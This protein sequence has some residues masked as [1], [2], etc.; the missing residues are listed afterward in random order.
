MI[1]SPVGE[2]VGQGFTQ[3]AGSAHA[4]VVALQ[5]AASQ[6]HDVRGA[7]AYV[8]M[9][10]CSHHGKTG[11][12]SEALI[13][14]GI[15]KVV[16]SVMDPNPLVSGRGFDRLRAAG[17]DVEIGPGAH[18]SRELNIGFFSRMLRKTPWVR[19]KIA[20]SLDGTTGLDN[21]LS[22]WITS[23]P[24][25]ADG[26]TWRARSCAILTGSGTILSDDP[27]L[28]VRGFTMPRQPAVVVVDSALN[29][30]LDAKIF[31][32][33]RDCYI[34]TTNRTS[35]AKV[36]ALTKRGAVVI[37]L[38]NN[39][40]KVDLSA[41]L[42]DLGQRGINELHVEAGHKLNGSLIREGLVDEVLVY[43]APRLLG[44]GSGM[45]HFGPLQALT[46]GVELEFRSVEKMGSDIR[47]CARV[48]GR[49]RF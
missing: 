18:E 29:V 12:C 49:D 8:T 7:T 10:P 3:Q 34:Y 27:Q 39:N 16:A 14:A 1:V 21:G 31:R 19:I 42:K 17:M 28:D 23:P 37:P 5:N 47:I 20:A 9:E 44:Q 4:E 35:T 13:R 45:A 11:P 46:E 43:L 24:S 48:A 6:G 30:P 38:E 33:D 22:Q 2:V 40:G 25:R 32:A 26:H 41:M 15:S 36:T